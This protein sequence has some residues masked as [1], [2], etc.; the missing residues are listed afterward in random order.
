M[1]QL[2]GL[3]GVKG[4]L[5]CQHVVSIEHAMRRIQKRRAVT[6][7]G[8]TGALNV[9]RDDGRRLRS[10]FCQYQQTVNEAEHAD[11][12]SLRA[13]LDQWWPK[14]SREDVAAPGEEQT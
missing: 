5:L 10:C 1:G 8:A 12:E 7:A 13:W 11:L 4:R 9:W 2:I 14:L 6:A 3:T